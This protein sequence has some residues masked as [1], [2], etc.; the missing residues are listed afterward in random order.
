M[1]II[2]LPATAR[3][4]K[5]VSWS[6]DR[7]AQVNRSAWTGRRQVIANPW[8]GKWSASVEL[9][10]IIGEPA[11]RLWRAFL[12]RLKG[13]VNSFELPATEGPQH[14]YATINPVIANHANTTV[15][16]QGGGVYRVTKTGGVNGSADA[17]AVSATAMPGDFT[18]RI[19]TLQTNKDIGFGVNADPL[20]DDSYTSIDRMLLFTAGAAVVVYENGSSVVA[21]A[22]YVTSQYWFIR[23]TGSAIEIR[24]GTSTDIALSSLVANFT[25]L[26]GTL[27]FDSSLLGSSGAADVLITMSQVPVAASG[28]ALG[29]TTIT[30]D[31]AQPLTAGMLATVTLPSGAR[32]MV[33]LTADIAGAVIAFEPPLREAIS[34]GAAIETAN[35]VCQVALTDS[36]ISWSVEPGKIYA[37]GTLQVDEAF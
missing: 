24:V 1:G 6:L 14:V 22:S 16:A 7:P 12:A 20:T 3:F 23:R 32:Q 31:A 15:A 18:I 27:Y 4:A 17:S 34:A 21:P 35:P 8:H 36:A 26:S 28:A 2:P 29:A 5:K 30:L 25:S 11:V 13:Q 37:I 10:P 19:Q 9:V 33:A